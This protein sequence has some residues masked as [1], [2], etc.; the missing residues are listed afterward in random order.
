MVTLAPNQVATGGTATA[1]PITSSAARTIINA[2]PIQTAVAGS[3]TTVNGN[4]AI[5]MYKIVSTNNGV[6]TLVPTTSAGPGTVSLIASG[7]G[8]GA[9][10]SYTS[11]VQAAQVATP[12]LVSKQ[13]T[14][15]QPATNVASSS[16]KVAIFSQDQQAKNALCNW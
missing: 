14:N 8:S 6:P 10:A 2:T 5:K 3:T 1:I 9:T 13:V 12:V 11:V 4:G 16:S 7:A 15:Q